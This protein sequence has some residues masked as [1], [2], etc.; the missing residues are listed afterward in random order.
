MCHL[1]SGGPFYGCVVVDL[2][3][4]WVL[5]LVGVSHHLAAAC[6]GFPSFI[7]HCVCVCVFVDI[8]CN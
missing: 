5:V 6:Q 2:V 7:G 1:L 8:V 4:N 3:C